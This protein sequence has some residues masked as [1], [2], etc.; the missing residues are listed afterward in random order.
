MSRSN[1]GNNKNFPNKKWEDDGGEYEEYNRSKLK[2]EAQEL[3]EETEEADCDLV[4]FWSQ[5]SEE[6]EPA[7]HSPE[8]KK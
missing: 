5:Q 6:E 3:V 7:S 2:R 1:W 4:P 8:D